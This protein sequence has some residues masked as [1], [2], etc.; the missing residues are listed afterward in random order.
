VQSIATYSADVLIPTLLIALTVASVAPPRVLVLDLKN[1]GASEAVRVVVQDELAKRISKEGLNVVTTADIQHELNLEAQKQAIGC[2]DESC[3]VEIANALGAEFTVYGS[4]VSLNGLTVVNLTLL[5]A[6]RQVAMTRESF[7]T[8]DTDTL[9]AELKPAVHRLVA[10]IAP[11]HGPP[12]L[13]ITGVSVAGLGLVTAAVGT[14]ISVEAWVVIKSERTISEA[15]PDAQAKDDALER[16]D[17]GLLIG[18]V[19]LGV[20]AAGTVFAAATWE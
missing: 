14:A 11:P 20:I 9:S 18:G 3:M 1:E 17:L 5:D 2:G 15:G 12:V 8:R 4:I 16:F 10:P 13:G 19:G 6:Q 7:Q